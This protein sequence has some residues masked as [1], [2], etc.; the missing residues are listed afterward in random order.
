MSPQE[1]AG[2]TPACTSLSV[3]GV[4]VTGGRALQEGLGLA[5]EEP[6]QAGRTAHA[7][8]AEAGLWS[9]AGKIMRATVPLGSGC[10]QPAGRDP[11][12]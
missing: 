3:E 2:A 1:T 12:S 5:T 11:W 7:P 9:L 8:S 10:A 6:T 4:E